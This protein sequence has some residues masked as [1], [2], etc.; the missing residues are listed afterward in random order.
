MALRIETFDNLRGGNT[1]YKALTH[2]HA[3]ECGRAIVRDLAHRGPTAIVDPQ[4]AAT[5]FAEIFGLQGVEIAGIYVQ[6]LARVGS[7]VLGH[8][9]RPLTELPESDAASVLI[10]AFD[11]ERLTEQIE[12]F[13]PAGGQPLSLDAMRIPDERL[14]NTRIYLDPLNFATNFALFRDT[15][16]LHTRLVSANYWANY[17]AR[18]VTCWLTLFDGDGKVIAEWSEPCGVQGRA[19][20]IDSREVRERFGLGDFAGQLF[21]HAVGAAGHDVVKYALD[22]YGEPGAAC[23]GA[24]SCTHDAN[25]WPSDRYAGLPAPAPG[26]RVILWIQNSHPTPIPP[27]AIGLNPMGEDAVVPLPAGI[28]PFASRAVDVAELLPGLAWPRQIEVRAGKHAVRP[29]YEIVA[30]DRRRIAHVNVERADLRP[31]PALLRLGELL[32]KG[33]L[34]PAPILPRCEWESVVLPT[35]MAEAQAELPIAVLIYDAGGNAIA[36]LPLGRLPRD[37]ATVLSLDA[38]AER[39]GDGYG[40]AELV[41]DFAEGGEGDGWLHALF[42]YRHRDSGHAAETSFGAHVFNTILTYRGEPQSYGGRPPGLSTRLF[43]RL[44]ETP[45]DTLCHLIYPASTPWRAHS[46]TDVVLHDREGAEIACE[47]LAIPCSGSRLFRYHALFDAVTRARAGAG[48]YAIIRDR[49]CR[50][51]GYHGL[52]GRNGAFSLDHMFGF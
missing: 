7:E 28:G 26:E 45:Y 22:T 1:L 11:A 15:A 6:D 43:L 20:V 42:R 49:T 52:L 34:L 38:A 44:G 29:R 4:G 27:G 25:A 16:T 31:D 36:R 12:R 35:P 2:P 33:Y 40:H 17:G 3:A 32:G 30:A 9:A 46:A 23:D 48:A 5:G 50:L 8:C 37:H 39:L 21:V 13:L 41:Y 10:A 51:F 24:L 14:S 47:S 18:S 19:L